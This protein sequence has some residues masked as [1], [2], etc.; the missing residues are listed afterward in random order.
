MAIPATAQSG[1]FN[2]NPFCQPIAG[3]AQR[4]YL[5]YIVG[6]CVCLS[7]VFAGIFH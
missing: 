1:V 4:L 3:G 7:I 5:H 6:V 2:T